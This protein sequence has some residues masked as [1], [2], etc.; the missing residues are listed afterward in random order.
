MSMHSE[1]AGN[2][3]CQRLSR[4]PVCQL[5]GCDCLPAS[6]DVQQSS[7]LSPFFL[8]LCVHLDDAAHTYCQTFSVGLNKGKSGVNSEVVV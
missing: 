7:P 6:I 1:V 2:T 3:R 5:Q 4:W 8:Q